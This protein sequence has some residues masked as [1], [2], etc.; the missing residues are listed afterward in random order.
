M[1]KTILLLFQAGNKLK[2]TTLFHLLKGKG[3]TSVLLF[4]FFQQ[5]LNFFGIYPKLSQEDYQQLLFKLLEKKYL[6]RSGDYLELTALG[7]AVLEELLIQYPL[8]HFNSYIYGRSEEEMWRS[9]KL[10]VQVVSQLSFH[11]NQYVPIENNPLLINQQKKWLKKVSKET[12]IKQ[13]PQ[14]LTE[15]FAQMPQKTADFLARQFSGYQLLGSLP[16]Q[17]SGQSNGPLAALSA[18]SQLHYFFELIEK[19]QPPLLSDLLAPFN[20]QNLNQSMQ[21]TKF[22]AQQGKTPAEIAAKRRLKIGTINDHLIEWAIQDSDFPTADFVPASVKAELAK[23][24][25]PPDTWN[26]KELAGSGQLDYLAFRLCQ[27][28]FFKKKG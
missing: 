1:A 8:E 18:R 21:Q 26:Y 4:G 9:V 3:S 2:E 6:I 5:N 19:T 11:N 27:I 20:L 22:L 28:D 15:I 16:F 13:L 17:L 7:K 10:A 25:L 23:L 14:E 24:S 12:L